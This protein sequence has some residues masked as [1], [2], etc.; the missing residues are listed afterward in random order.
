M[1]RKLTKEVD[2]VDKKIV[3]FLLIDADIT[4]RE[5]AS[6]C[7][8]ALG[9]VNNRLKKLKELGIIKKKTLL[10][11]YEKL[12]YMIEVIIDLKINKGEFHN[13]AKDFSGNP[14]VFMVIDMTGDYDAEILARFHT[15]R[16]LDAFVKKV[17]QNPAVVNTRTRLILNVYRDKEIT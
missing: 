12:G 16:Q 10:I 15:R 13:V 6:K 1:Q 8:I 11:D 7:S 9:T 14:N 17:Q 4:N 2:E 5:L 3:N